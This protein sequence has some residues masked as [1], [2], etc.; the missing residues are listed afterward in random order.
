MIQT[1]VFSILRVSD[2]GG[3]QMCACA[4]M[5]ACNMYVDCAQI[6]QA[7]PPVYAAAASFGAAPPE[8]PSPFWPF[9]ICF[10]FFMDCSTFS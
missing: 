7:T 1:E 3:D 4:C 2:L 6:K 5:H 8:A 10:I 9:S